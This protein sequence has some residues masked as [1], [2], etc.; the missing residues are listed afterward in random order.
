M[1]TFLLSVKAISVPVFDDGNEIQI[2]L[3]ETIRLQNT[4]IH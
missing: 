2:N 1:F 3:V 4:L